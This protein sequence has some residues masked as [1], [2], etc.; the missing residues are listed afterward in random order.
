MLKIDRCAVTTRYATSRKASGQVRGWQPMAN[1][2]PKSRQAARTGT[3]GD[4]S[5]SAVVDGT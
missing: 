4:L 1:A 5:M 3:R 2:K